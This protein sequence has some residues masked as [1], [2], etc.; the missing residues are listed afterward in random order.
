MNLPDLLILQAAERAAASR[1][2]ISTSAFHLFCLVAENDGRKLTEYAKLLHVTTSAIT[3]LADS[4]ERHGLTTRKKLGLDRRALKL[5]L[6]REGEDTVKELRM[7]RGA[8]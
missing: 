7:E 4:L 6:T 3:A 8:A 1:L 2:G 5:C